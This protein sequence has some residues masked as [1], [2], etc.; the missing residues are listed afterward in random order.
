[1]C[2]LGLGGVYFEA[3]G[4]KGYYNGLIDA[5]KAEAIIPLFITHDL[6]GYWNPFSRFSSFPNAAE[7]GKMNDSEV[8]ETTKG[9]ARLMKEMGFNMDFAPVLDLSYGNDVWPGRAFSTDPEVVSTKAVAFIRA[10]E[11]QNILVIA[12]HFP[13][14]TVSVADT[15][16]AS[17]TAEITE[18]DVTPFR[19]AVEAGVAGVMMN[20]LRTTGEVDS[21]GR[22]AS[23]SENA[24]AKLR[25]FYDGLVLTDDMSMQGVDSFYQDKNQKYIDAINAGND[26]LLLT[27]V[28]NT[29]EVEGVIQLIENAVNSEQI[30]GTLIDEAA[31]RILETKCGLFS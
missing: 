25:E 31:E 7:M 19:K 28:T 11:D 2:S 1:M 24:V 30:N 13:G 27:S 8:Y 20:H 12:K 9:M 10:F 16:I 17:A 15:H 4:S 3:M 14:K 6:E 21:G 29:Q 5:C 18:D 22:P 23:V 26:I